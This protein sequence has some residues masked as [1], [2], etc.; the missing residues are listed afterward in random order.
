MD[1]ENWLD[2]N[3]KK[4]WAFLI[5]ILLFICVFIFIDVR[6]LAATTSNTTI[7]LNTAEDYVYNS[8][9]TADG[10]LEIALQEY[11]RVFNFDPNGSVLVWSN[12]GYFNGYWFQYIIMYEPY[13]EEN[14]TDD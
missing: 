12:D 7:P 5:G 1:N 3:Y 2:R 4:V 11:Y 9:M 14:Y 10:R 13:C 6:V 8:C